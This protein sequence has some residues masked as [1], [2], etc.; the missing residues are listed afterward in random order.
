M[1]QFI[2]VFLSTLVFA[3]VAQAANRFPVI[4]YVGP[5][6]DLLTG[7]VH[8]IGCER[9]QYEHSFAL[10]VNEDND[11]VK[12]RVDVTFAESSSIITISEEIDG[13]WEVL[14]KEEILNAELSVH[15][16]SARQ[17]FTSGCKYGDW[18]APTELVMFY[19]TVQEVMEMRVRE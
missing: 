1:R 16:Q 7:E 18:K 5:S 19:V 4:T 12:Y 2:F 11:R 15:W 8:M 10:R 17:E 6:N 14:Q 3:G 9:G 13:A